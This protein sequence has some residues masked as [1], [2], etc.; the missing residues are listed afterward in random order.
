MRARKAGFL[1]LAAASGLVY[2]GGSTTILGGDASTDGASESGSGSGSGSSS[3]SSSGSGSSGG[4][5]SGGTG[6]CP[7]CQPGDL[8]CDGVSCSVDAYN[9]PLHCGA[10]NVVCAAPTP[11]CQAGKCIQT[12]CNGQPCATGT[13]C[14][15]Q[16][17]CQSGDICCEFEGPQSYVG[18]YTP[19]AQQPS[20]PPGCNTCVSDRNVKRDI[21]PVAPQAVLEGIARVPVA[22]WSYRSDDPSVR[23]MGPMAQDFY[24]EFG[25]GNTD[26]AY[27]P[28][29]ANG[30]A[31]AAIQ[32]LYERIKDQDARIE[33][34]EHENAGLR[35]AGGR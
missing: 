12:P 5:S 33:K 30:V 6:N 21:V 34:L 4:S 20:C 18:C 28:I 14:C 15:G 27:S 26:K 25:L 29:D 17:C 23:H 22:T 8:C 24:G 31:F 9:D 13:S 35:R 1:V 2:C 10:C 11:F 16:S 32:A 19:T 7:T 3:G